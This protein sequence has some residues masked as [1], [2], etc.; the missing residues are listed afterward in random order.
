VRQRERAQPG[1]ERGSA[2]HPCQRRDWNV[3]YRMYRAYLSSCIFWSLAVPVASMAMLDGICEHAV[4]IYVP[5]S[6]QWSN[7]HVKSYSHPRARVHT[8]QGDLSRGKLISAE[9]CPEQRGVVRQIPRQAAALRQIPSN[10]VKFRQILRGPSV[11]FRQIRQIR[12][13]PDPARALRQIPDPARPPGLMHAQ[14]LS[15]FT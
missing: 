9:P 6:V 3:I 12:Q 14:S 8:D 11:K 10:S 4:T 2:Q 1:S 13:I 5:G 15:N 7:K